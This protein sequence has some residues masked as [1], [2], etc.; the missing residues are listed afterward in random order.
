MLVGLGNKE[1]SHNREENGGVG[2][3]LQVNKEET[4]KFTLNCLANTFELDPTS[5]WELHSRKKKLLLWNLY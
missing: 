3:K 5:E 4:G 1:Q 2:E